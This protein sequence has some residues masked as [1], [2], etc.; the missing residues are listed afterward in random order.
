MA[1]IILARVGIGNITLID[2][3]IV[4]A[5]N[6]NRQPLCTVSS[7]GQD[8]V[9]AAK[10]FLLDCNPH[11]KVSAVKNRVTEESEEELKGHDVILQCVDNF[12]ARVAIHRVARRLGIPVVSMTGQPPYRS[13]VS[14]F[15][16]EGPEYEDVMC[17][18]SIGKPLNEKVV[19]VLNDLRVERA[20]H[21]DE[22]G[23]AAGW[24]KDFVNGKK[25]W[26]DEPVGWAITP[27]RAYITATI[28]A[29]E[30]LRIVT[31]RPVLATAPT[32]VVT[33]LLNPPNLVRVDVPADGKHWDWREF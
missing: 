32:A 14:T 6:L 11:V 28:Q 25:G 7:L 9:V 23:A 8:K 20:K 27:E 5:S 18:P 17:L 21:A 19:K 16:P 33:D 26:G 1:T 31:G 4:E 12:P 10:N 3:D 24:W 15:F 22:S 2:F 30:T 13:H 29:H